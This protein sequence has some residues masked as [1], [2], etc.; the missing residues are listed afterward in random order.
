MNCISGVR[1]SLLGVVGSNCP[2][3]RVLNIANARNVTDDGIARIATGCP[4][5]ENLDLSWC[6]RVTDWSI[7]KLSSGVPF[8]RSLRLSETRVTDVGLSEVWRGCRR[9][10]S[11]HLARCLHVT[12]TGVESTIAHCRIRLRS[13][14][15]ASCE[16]VTDD[17]VCRLMHSCPVL[18]CRDVSMLPCREISDTLDCISR[19]RNVQVYF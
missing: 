13:L 4:R 7:L 15:L 9:L 19:F 18:K 5:L 17:Y 3:L 10:E 8:L 14:N 12:N 11:M 1:D 16:I 6:S 2:F